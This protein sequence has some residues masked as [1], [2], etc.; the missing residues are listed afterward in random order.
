M[1]ITGMAKRFRERS[2]HRSYPRTMDIYEQTLDALVQNDPRVTNPSQTV[3]RDFQLV[4]G[5]VYGVKCPDRPEY[6]RTAFVK[7]NPFTS[8][9]Q[10]LLSNPV[11]GVIPDGIREVSAQQL[12]RQMKTPNLTGF[13]A[14]GADYPIP[15]VKAQ[16][17][18]WSKGQ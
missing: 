7:L 9:P 2:L 10:V 6:H 18:K 13:N 14:F 5:E 3:Q 8:Q 1:L 12:V 15:E 17:Q 16:H 4:P 11:Y